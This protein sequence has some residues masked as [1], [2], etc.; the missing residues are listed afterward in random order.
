MR[1]DQ[2]VKK[3]SFLI[4]LMP[5]LGLADDRPPI[6][7]DRPGF[8]DGSNVMPPGVLQAEGGIFRTQTGKAVNFSAGDLTLRYGIGRNAELRLVGLSYGF[9]PGDAK[10]WL[11]PSIGF[12]LRV[13]QGRGEVTLIGVTTIPVGTSPLRANEWNPTGKIAWTLPV[14]KDTL[15]GNL[16]VG[17]LG[18]GAGRFTQSALSVYLG[19][20]VTGR[21][22]LIPELW[23][24]DK[25]GK[26]GKAGGFGSLAAAYLLNNDT[27]IDLRIGTGFNQSRDGWL[28]QAGISFRF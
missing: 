14:G 9:A 21:L 28:L 4:L 17:R 20:P 5:A 18:S 1:D 22:T 7:T 13:Y 3:L 8:S 2:I 12:K 10:A 6:A 25:V 15:G 27:Q 26:G 23:A 11:D 24:V 16:V 19:H